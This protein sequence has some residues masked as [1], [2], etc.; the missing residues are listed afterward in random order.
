MYHLAILGGTF[1]P[2]HNGHIKTSLKIQEYFQ[3]EHFAFLPCKTPVLK[4]PAIAS[5]KQRIQM[6][7]LALAELNQ[8]YSNRPFQLDLREQTRNTPS[9]TI[10][11][12]ESLR[13]QFPKASIQLI[14]GSDAFASLPKWHRFKD[15]I[16]LCNLLVIKRPSLE[17]VPVEHFLKNH[18][19][20]S[21][22]T[23]LNHTAGYIYFFDAGQYDISSSMIRTQLRQGT[24]KPDLLPKTIYNYIVSSKL[25]T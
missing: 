2:V 23:L 8:G 1:D 21:K 11:T 20:H 18:Q 10:E 24:L 25:Y 19:T 7:E 4:S 15:I 5:S 9:Y 6:L 12:L 22:Q 17:H 16:Q 14:L 13:A 3:F